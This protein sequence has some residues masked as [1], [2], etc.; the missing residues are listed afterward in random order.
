MDRFRQ[1]S[2]SI[3]IVLSRETKILTC[4]QSIELDTSVILTWCWN[5]SQ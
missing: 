5:Y 4:A 1:G 3:G 2:S